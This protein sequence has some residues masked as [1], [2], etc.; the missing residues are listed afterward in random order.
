M[1]RQQPRTTALAGGMAAG[2]RGGRNSH[3]INGPIL[4]TGVGNA[5]KVLEA[6]TREARRCKA[7]IRNVA[8]GASRVQSRTTGT[9][10]GFRRCRTPG[11]AAGERRL[12]ELH[13]QALPQRVV[14]DWIARRVREIGK[15]NGVSLSQNV[16][17]KL[18]EIEITR[19][20]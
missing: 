19:H 14:E 20:G 6:T 16:P 17:G 1:V 7:E 11:E 5:G 13:R 4:E 3:G 10:E 8:S 9:Q 12:L 2:A 15:D 18:T